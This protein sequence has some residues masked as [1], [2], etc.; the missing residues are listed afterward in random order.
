MGAIPAR[1]PRHEFVLLLVAFAGELERVSLGQQLVSETTS[2]TFAQVLYLLFIVLGVF[3]RTSNRDLLEFWSS[4][5][6]SE[7]QRAAAVGGPP[8]VAV[9]L[10]AGGAPRGIAA[11]SRSSTREALF[12][13]SCRATLVSVS[14]ALVFALLTFSPPFLAVQLTRYQVY[15]TYQVF[16]R[17]PFIGLILIAMIWGV[18]LVNTHCSTDTH[19]P[20][21]NLHPAPI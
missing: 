6:S 12:A 11:V 18:S 1:I 10:I 21:C 2:V 15:A 16:R 8:V 5:R 13:P 3:N 4:G 9:V 17:N 19:K 7:Q 14:Y 20:I